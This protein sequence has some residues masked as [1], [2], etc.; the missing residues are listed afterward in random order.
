[1]LG[2]GRRSVVAQLIASQRGSALFCEDLL[3]PFELEALLTDDAE[4]PGVFLLKVAKPFGFVG[5]RIT[6]LLS[7]GVEGSGAAPEV[8]TELL[9]RFIALLS[10]LEQL[11]DL[12]FGE[13]TGF[14][15]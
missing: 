3:H 15:R 4:E 8:A 11:D 2:R 14:H 13:L 5:G 6:V 10:V 9:D 1:M 12:G 7:P